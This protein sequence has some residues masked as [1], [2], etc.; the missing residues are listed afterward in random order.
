VKLVKESVAIVIRNPEH[1]AGFLV[2][3]RPDN[4]PDIPSVWELPAAS[5]K[6]GET[7][8]DAAHRCAQ[9]KLGVKISLGRLVDEGS[10]EKGDHTQHM[11][12]YE[13]SIEE[14]IPLV[15]QP[16]A[17]MTQYTQWKWGDPETL[18]EAAQKGS[19]CSRL[20]LGSIDRTW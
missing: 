17:G 5:L 18:I 16:H 2:V 4:D 1:R 15:P 11:K 19:L 3:K 13:A 12:E 20:Y 8:E 7:Y 9:E 10:L 6:K 14:G